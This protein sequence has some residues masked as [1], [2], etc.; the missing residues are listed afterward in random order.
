MAFPTE[1][2]YGLG[3]RVY[4]ERAIQRIFTIKGRVDTN[5]LIVHI[6]SFEQV[7]ALVS[8][9]PESAERLMGT[10]WPGPLTMV[11]QHSS[12]I[13]RAVTRGLPTVAVRM[14]N[15]PVALSLIRSLGEPVAAPSANRSGR[16]S[17]THSAHVRRDLENGIDMILDAGTCRI[18]I[19]STVVDMTADI[20]CILRSG[21]ITQD[22][23]QATIGQTASHNATNGTTKPKSPG[24]H[25]RHYAPNCRIIPVPPDAWTATLEQWHGS[26]QQIGILCH[27]T[28]AHDRSAAFFRHIPP[29]PEAYAKGLFAAFLDAEA[30]HIDVLLVETVT[31][32]GIGVAIMDRIYRAQVTRGVSSFETGDHP[33]A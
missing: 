10:F 23:I 22:M 1:T 32:D 13:P 29:P 12:R 7:D 20:P 16:P 21:A 17:P 6:A 33:D 28:I 14:P 11:L 24:M 15:H 2:V 3:A 9:I 4:D 8:H 30:A 5:P 31:E 25:Q 27:Q 26:G 19:E 18:G